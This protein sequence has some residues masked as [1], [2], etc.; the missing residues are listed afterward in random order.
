[1]FTE[2]TQIDQ[3]HQT[4]VATISAREMTGFDMQELV[5]ELV[6]RMRYDN[7]RYFILDLSEVELIASECLGSLV[8]FLRD[9]EPQRGRI[10]LANCRPNVSFLFK[11]TRLDAVFEVF[12]DVAAAKEEIVP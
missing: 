4:V 2:S 9:I 1:M 12:D 11:V 6:G 8:M 10:A 5:N 3:S 7:A